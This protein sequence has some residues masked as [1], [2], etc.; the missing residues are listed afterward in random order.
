M[1]PR[2]RIIRANRP[3]ERPFQ[4]SS[5]RC[6]ELNTE[7]VSEAGNPLVVPTDRGLRLRS[8]SAVEPQLCH[9]RPAAS[10]RARTVSQASSSA[11]PA[12]ISST[13][14]LIS[15]VQAAAASESSGSRLWIS[16]CAIRARSPAASA[17]ASSRTRA[18]SAMTAFYNGR[19]ARTSPAC[20][21][22]RGSAEGLLEVSG[23]S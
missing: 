6:F 4:D 22:L 10:S 3:H 13:R 19:A 20:P 1:T 12:S 5:D 8:R 7:V 16:S 2:A 15:S 9:V 23:P 14:R 21:R 18:A 17:S 11:V